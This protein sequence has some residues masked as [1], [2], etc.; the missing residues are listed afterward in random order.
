[1]LNENFHFVVCP[2]VALVYFLKVKNKNLLKTY[3][4][5]FM[6][7]IENWAQNGGFGEK[8]SLTLVL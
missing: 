2:N 6:S 5:E 4:I 7:K 3:G 1:V 8:G